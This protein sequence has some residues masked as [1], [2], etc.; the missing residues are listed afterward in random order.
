MNKDN[1]Y[2][3]G[4]LGHQHSGNYNNGYGQNAAYVEFFR[5]YGDVII[6]DSQC[7]QV[8]PVDLLILPGGRDV[9]PE[10]YG[11]KPLLGTQSPDLEYEWFFKHM[12]DK[13]VERTENNKTAIYGICAG[14]QNLIV[15]FGGYLNQSAPQKQST[16]FRGELVDFLEFNIPIINKYQKLKESYNKNK[17]L[18][19][20]KKTNSIHHQAAY[21]E[22]ITSDFEIIATNTNYKNVE[23]I[24]HNE[25]PIAAEQSHPEERLNP[26]LTDA[27]IKTI[28]NKIQ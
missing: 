7:E 20:F 9:N 3:I 5:Q 13:Y 10:R 24:I 4:I 6:I 27:I 23:F 22:D 19:D 26:L 14:F 18:I 21:E 11:Q 16:D 2:L 28:L 12:F 1:N 8:I 15:E 17:N 25:L